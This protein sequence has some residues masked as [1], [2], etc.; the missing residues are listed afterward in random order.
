MLYFYTNFPLLELDEERQNC[1]LVKPPYHSFFCL[2]SHCLGDSKQHPNQM[3]YEATDGE[4]WLFVGSNVF[5]DEPI[6]GRNESHIELRIR[7][8][9]KL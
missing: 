5:R 8:Q 7:N 9:I 4:N 1:N 6:I 3:S 2:I